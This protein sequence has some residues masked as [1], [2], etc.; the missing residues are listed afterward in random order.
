M[1]SLRACCRLLIAVVIL[2]PVLVRC[3]EW[4]ERGSGG[5]LY[6]AI[7]VATG[8]SGNCI[9]FPLLGEKSGTTAWPL[10]RCGAN[11]IAVHRRH[12]PRG[13][14][15]DTARAMRSDITTQISSHGCPI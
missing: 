13:G 3:F 10:L 6:V 1:R 4:A 7:G 15:A 12:L 14:D 5:S 8:Q 11:K 9:D 2:L